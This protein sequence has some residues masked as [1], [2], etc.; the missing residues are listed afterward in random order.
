MV[1]PQPGLRPMRDLDIL[2]KAP[3]A[4][5]AQQLLGHLGFS[6]PLPGSGPL[7]DKHLATATRPCEGLTVSVELHHNLFNIFDPASMTLAQLSGP[8]L[9]FSLDGVTAYTLSGEDM[10]WHLCQHIAYHASIWEPIRLIWVADV[11]GFAEHFAEQIN[12]ARVTRCYPL[13]LN[14]L[15]LFHFITPLS[16]KLRGL[17]RLKIGPRPP[18]GVGQEFAGFPRYRLKALRG[19]SYRHVLHETFFP[20]EWWLRLHYRLNSA[21]SLFWYRWFR[22][23]LYI[24]GPL[25][26]AEKLRLWWYLKLRRRLIKDEG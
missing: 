19:Q 20:S 15:S 18:Q 26:L 5:Q 14:T 17:A 2:V 24:L 11:V 10:L 16:E 9:S 23:P 22:H 8:P 4:R 21:Q 7:P 13:A 12:W 6:A 1:Y 3:Q 25:Y